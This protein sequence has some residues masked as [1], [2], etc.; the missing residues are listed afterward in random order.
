M[1]N[2]A[3]KKSQKSDAVQKSFDFVKNLTGLGS[4]RRKSK[5]RKKSAAPT[6]KNQQAETP[7]ASFD[8][9]GTSQ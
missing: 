8:F 3:G 1:K 4:R 7:Q 9:T 6:G 2:R 5:S